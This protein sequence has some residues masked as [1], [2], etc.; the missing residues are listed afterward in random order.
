MRRVALLVLL[1]LLVAGTAGATVRIL[2]LGDSMTKGSTQTPAEAS[3]P[4]YRYWLWQQLAGKDVDFVG[5]WTAPNFAYDFDQDNEGH[6]GYMT[7]G[8]LNGVAD[9]PGQGKLSIWLTKYQFDIALVMLGTNDV[10]NAIPTA[11]SA[12]NLEAIIAQ[13]RAKNP[14]AVILLAKIPPTSFPRPGIEALNA[15]IPGVAARTSTPRSPVVVVDMYTGYDGVADNQAPLGIHPAESGEKKI[16][17]RWY[18]ALQPYLGAGPTPSATPSPTPTLSPTPSP[19]AS[20]VPVTP[21]TAAPNVIRSPGA[22]VY[23]GE[24][25]L[26]VTAAGI[27]AGDTLGWFANGPSGGM[28]PDATLRIADPKHAAI[29]HD[30]RTG[31]WYDLDRGRA[32]AL[33]VEEPAL[34]LRLIDA[35]TGRYVPGGEAAKGRRFDLEVSGSLS[36]FAARGSGAP[37]AVR[38]RD[39]TGR[40]VSTLV[41]DGGASI[42]LDRLMITTTPYRIRGTSGAAWNTGDTVYGAGAYTLWAEGL[43]DYEHGTASPDPSGAVGRQ[44]SAPVQLAVAVAPT[45]VPATS[46]PAT[47]VRV[48]TAPSTAPPTA[49]TTAPQ[50]TVTVATATATTVAPSTTT[51]APTPPA[52]GTSWWF[53]Y[54]LGALAL[55]LLLAGVGVWW[56]LRTPGPSDSAKPR[57]RSTGGTPPGKQTVR[58][59]PPALQIALD[60][61]RTWDPMRGRVSTLEAALRDLEQAERARTGSNAVDLLKLVPPEWIPSRPM[62]EPIRS[63]G[64]RVGFVPLSV[65][66]YGDVLFYSPTPHQGGTRLVVKRA[67]ELLDRLGGDGELRR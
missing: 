17:A 11:E 28:A 43:F 22:V 16:A 44:V 48:T 65:D 66:R 4:T 64:A 24:I 27:G 33:T 7:G 41:G 26:D 58:G 63:W 36:A 32:L 54:F 8:I 47:S 14:N 42:S 25:G 37:V 51:N 1:L 38:I 12:R 15:A 60:R 59:S 31:A 3:H 46:I 55:L 56:A 34:S 29:P 30:A 2:P 21:G 9:D 5:S 49:G 39:P 13:L 57:P 18:A 6:G 35:E 19:S 52:G 40:T 45:T 61:L 10:L 67:D 50:T 53:P 62:P 20:S 23:A